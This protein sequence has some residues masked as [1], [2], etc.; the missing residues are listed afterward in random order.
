MT[1]QKLIA[2]LLDIRIN[3]IMLVFDGILV[4]DFVLFL[5]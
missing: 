1:T 2:E 4:L 3:Q 5:T